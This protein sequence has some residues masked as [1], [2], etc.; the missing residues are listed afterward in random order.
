MN[1]Q[2]WWAGLAAAVLVA[3]AGQAEYFGEPARH[4][5]SLGGIV[6][7]AIS[8]FML[9]PPGGK[10]AWLLPLALAASLTS[11]CSARQFHLETV[12]VVAAESTA[13]LVQDEADA[14]LCGKPT[15]P[16]APQCL[17]TDQRKAISPALS[18]AFD[19]IGQSAQTVKTMGPGA[20]LGSV[21]IANL[22]RITE[23][24]N[25]VLAL[26]P[27]SAQARVKTLTTGGK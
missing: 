7:T 20:T 4:W 3:V 25:R 1:Q 13:A 8:G 24:L 11:G 2:A 18:E 22:Q 9:H 16:P 27:S 10:A 19:L 17:S 5:I 12:S 23:L 6:G 14:S 15:A 21:L 26:L